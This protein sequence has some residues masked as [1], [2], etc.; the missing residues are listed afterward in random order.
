MAAPR[1]RIT[2]RNLALLNRDLSYGEVV[3]YRKVPGRGRRYYDPKRPANPPVTDDYVFRVYKPRLNAL[4]RQRI[5]EAARLNVQQQRSNR[6]SLLSTWMLRQQALG[7]PVTTRNEAR[8]NADFRQAYQ[9][10]RQVKY[11][12]DA[13]SGI[14]NPNR[15]EYKEPGSEYSELLVELGRRTGEENFPVGESEPNYVESVVIPYLQR[16]IA[17]GTAQPGV[18]VPTRE[19]AAAQRAADRAQEIALR[20]EMRGL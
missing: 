19:E 3:N 2:P 7:Q 8:K 15:F 17:S 20:R 9:Q 16:Q 4:D 13:N 11:E 18:P 6:E 5:N 12:V 1:A 10:F 14:E